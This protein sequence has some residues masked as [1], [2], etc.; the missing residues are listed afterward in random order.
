MT[1]RGINE[2]FVRPCLSKPVMSHDHFLEV[3]KCVGRVPPGFKN[4]KK[5]R[6]FYVHLQFLFLKA[7]HSKPPIKP[8]ILIV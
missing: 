2:T 8:Y 7:R 3:A 4:K 6:R 1:C 5:N